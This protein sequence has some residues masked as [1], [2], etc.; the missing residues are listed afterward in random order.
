[1][2]VPYRSE[3]D[4][5]VGGEGSIDP[6]GLAALADRLADWIFPGM[7]ARMWRPR[8][9]TAM[10]AASVIVEPFADALAKDGTT[11]PW[12]IFEW[13]Y[14]EPI[15]RLPEEEISGQRIPGILK[16]QQAA[17][18]K[19]PMNPARYLKTPKVFGF[20]GVYKTLATH[21]KVL[22]NRL[23]LNENGNQ[24]LKIWEQEQG[25]SGYRDGEKNQGAG[26]RFRRLFQDAIKASLQSCQTE[27]PAS[28]PG[29]TFVL[30]H[31][32]PHRPG[33]GE[34]KFLWELLAD[35]NADLRGELFVKLRDKDLLKKFSDEESERSLL[36]SIRTRVADELRRR[37]DAI[38]AYENFCRPLHEGFDRLQFLSSARIPGVINVDDFANDQRI[39]EIASGLQRSM[40]NARSGLDG[41][42]IQS[43]FE[44]LV[45]RFETVRS[46]GDLFQALCEHHNAV[47]KGK[48]PEGKRPWFETTAN[49][50]VIVRPP[51]RIDKNPRRR[52]EF[53]HDLALHRIQENRAPRPSAFLTKRPEQISLGCFAIQY[54]F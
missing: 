24:L 13:Y 15:A 32:A 35:K 52:E 12:L 19:V 28:W 25:L 45:Q 43:G 9:L 33:T 22:D 34:R 48:P 38:E 5:E 51:Y 16:A 27:K 29:A 21:S 3:F 37:L 47:Q 1:V 44:S 39:S 41:S 10:A 20:H 46:G 36:K 49:G 50:G 6:L 14:I 42:P 30:N 23:M 2:L 4:P 40:T 53:V 17:R 54:Y 26:A 31:L 7:T 18:D 8:F 11:P